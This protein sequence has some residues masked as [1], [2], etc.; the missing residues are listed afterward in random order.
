MDYWHV[1][2]AWDYEFPK[3]CMESTYKKERKK[4]KKKP[5][6]NYSFQINLV[7]PSQFMR[8]QSCHAY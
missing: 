6:G 4:K 7:L 3:G 8:Q 5:R 1:L 2:L